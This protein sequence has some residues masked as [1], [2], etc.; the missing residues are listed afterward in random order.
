MTKAGCDAE[1]GCIACDR[2]EEKERTSRLQPCS[3]QRCHKAD[4]GRVGADRTEE[5]AAVEDC[6]ASKHCRNGRLLHVP[7]ADGAQNSMREFT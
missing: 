1:G 4:E 5:D 3:D 7:V 2:N 6:Q